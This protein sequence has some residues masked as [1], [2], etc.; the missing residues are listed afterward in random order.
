MS[1]ED[2][3]KRE[4][5]RRRTQIISAAETVIERKGFQQATMDEIAE[6]AELSKGTLYLYFSHKEAL[7]LAINKKGL[8]K[9]NDRFLHVMQQDQQGIELVKDLGDSFLSFITSNPNYTKALIYYESV[10][11]EEKL[12]ENEPAQ[13]CE[14]IGRQLLMYLTRAIQIGMQDGSITNQMEPKLLAVQIWGSMRGMMQLYQVRSQHHLQ[15]MLQDLE[16]NMETMIRQFLDV[17]I[18]GIQTSN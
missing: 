14:E 3:K 1:T 10:I 6:E 17:Q 7:Y 16:M 9:L 11:N 2:R 15:K 4:Q 12:E 18:K 8:Q 5:Q 13:E